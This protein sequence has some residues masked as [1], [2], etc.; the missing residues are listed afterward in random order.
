MKFI[1]VWK[2]VDGL[3]YAMPDIHVYAHHAEQQMKR[4]KKTSRCIDAK[5]IKVDEL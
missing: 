2:S 4:I 1:V 5:V 3:I